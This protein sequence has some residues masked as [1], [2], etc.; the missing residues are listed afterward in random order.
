M[1]MYRLNIKN[2]INLIVTALSLSSVMS[3]RL[4]YFLFF[5][6]ITFVKKKKKKKRKTE[7]KREPFMVSFMFFDIQPTYLVIF[8]NLLVYFCFPFYPRI[9]MISLNYSCRNRQ[10]SYTILSLVTTEKMN[11]INL[12]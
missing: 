7:K 6:F 5:I 1:Y 9:I 2:L 11:E 4:F 10:R 8:P 3:N 12:C